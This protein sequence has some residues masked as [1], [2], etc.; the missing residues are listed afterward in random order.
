MGLTKDYS[1][2]I[3]LQFLNLLVV[4]ENKR[5]FSLFFQTH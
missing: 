5:K 1:L 3:I 4:P 2:A